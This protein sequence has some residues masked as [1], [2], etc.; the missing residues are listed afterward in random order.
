MKISMD[1]KY[2]TRDGREVRLLCVDGPKEYP[3][4]GVVAGDNCPSSWTSTGKIVEHQDRQADLIEYHEPDIRTI[5]VNVY[6]G[7]VTTHGSEV[8]AKAFSLS[9]TAISIAQPVTFEVKRK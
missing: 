6:E 9:R 1:K 4:V 3:V 5:W 7:S 2:R 8:E